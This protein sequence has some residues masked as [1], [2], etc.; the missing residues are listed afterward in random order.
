MPPRLKS[1]LVVAVLVAAP[2]FVAGCGQPAAVVEGTVT[3]E[4]KPVPEGSIS[5]EAPDGSIPTF[6]GAIKDGAYRVEV[7]AG[8]PARRVVRVVASR[9]TGRKVPAGPPFPPGTMLDEIERAPARYNDRSTL[10]TD[11]RPGEVTRFDV[12][13]QPDRPKP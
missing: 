12:D 2:L 7:P 8:G 1:V 3:F 11:L 9:L 10:E 5:F 13:I 4:G 6:G